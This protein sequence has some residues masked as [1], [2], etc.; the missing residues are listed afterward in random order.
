MTKLWSQTDR[1][2]AY[3]S[4]CDA[5]T[6]AGPGQETHVLARLALLL[7]EELSDA[8][9]FARALAAAGTKDERTS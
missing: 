6:A 1:E 5:L 3:I 4:L 8:S 2:A 9:A 7:A